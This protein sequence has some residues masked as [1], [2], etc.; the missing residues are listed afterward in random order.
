MIYR[1]SLKQK[2]PIQWTGLYA[3]RNYN[4][5]AQQGFVH[6]VPHFF[7]SALAQQGFVQSAPQ[8][9]STFLEAQQAYLADF[10]QATFSASEQDF[11]E[12]SHFAFSSGEQAFSLEAQQAFLDAKA[13]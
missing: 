13:L 2:S 3:F 12:A 4:Y 1:S 8:P 5:L 6:S 9:F 11:F 7:S 10:S